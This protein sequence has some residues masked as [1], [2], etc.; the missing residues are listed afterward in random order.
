[1]KNKYKISVIVPVY[2]VER[3][4]DECIK[5]VLN[6]TIDFQKNIQL[7]LV[8]D[9]SPDNSEAICKKYQEKY[10]DNIIYIKQKNAGVSAARNN[11]LKYATGEYINFLDSDDK[12]DKNAFKNGIEIFEKNP[13][14]NLIC[15]RIKNFEGNNDY[16]ILS[17]KFDYNKEIIDIFEDNDCIESHVCNFLIRRSVIGDVLFD[18]NLKYAEDTKFINEILVDNNKIY[19][20]KDSFYFYRKRKEQSSATQKS[21]TDPSYYTSVKYAFIEPFKLFKNKFS[22]IPKYF[23]YSIM[24]QLTYRIKQGIGTS[25]TIKDKEDYINDIKILLNEIDDDVII[26]QRNFNINNKILAL[27]IKYGDS[28]FNKIRFDDKYIYINS[29]IIDEV[30]NLE[31]QLIQF[32]VCNDKLFVFGSVN[33]INDFKLSYKINSKEYSIKKIYKT[34]MNDDFNVKITSINYREYINYKNGDKLEFYIEISGKKYKLKNTF[35]KFSRLNNIINYYYENKCLFE[36]ND[37]LNEIHIENNPSIFKVL[38]LEIRYLMSI[39]LKYKRINVFILRSLYWLTKPFINHNIYLFCDRE[40]MAGDSGEIL[41]KYFNKHNKDKKNKSYFVVDKSSED[42]NKIKEYGNVVSYHTMKY[43]ILFLHSKVI[44]SSHADEYVSNAFGN[45]RKYY[46]DLY[47]F[48]YVYLTHGILL[49]DSSKW[50]NRINK[51]FALNV[52]TSPMEYDSIINGNYYFEK[53]ELIKTGIPRYDNLMNLDVKEENKILF[54]P[55]WRSTLVGNAIPGTQQRPYNPKFKD[56]EYFKFYDKLLNDK[57]LL[58]CLEENNLKIRFC[59]HP[60][61][62]NQKQ[63]FVGNDYVEYITDSNSQYE[64]LSSKM[65]VTDYSSAACDF[66]YLNKP[67]VYANF[68]YD[69]IYDVHY[70]NKGYFDYDEHGFGPNCSNY[71]ETKKEILKLIKNNFKVEKKYSERMKNFFYYRDNKNSE[72]VYN[73]I[74]KLMK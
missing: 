8:D 53:N 63:D 48:K 11:G 35:V 42:Y 51:N 36:L 54:M 62:R 12:W 58:D 41:F 47:K 3:Y 4:L 37:D 30:S 39:L 66:A 6:Q 65:V 34:T 20:V 33:F 19:L 23:Q 57:E 55:S 45:A 44:I 73:E 70:Y 72:R 40:F 59:I 18:T 28:I 67:V 50:L 15:F 25:L 31:N 68:D 64:T 10:S 38:T 49:H 27:Y 26:N 43:R 24:Y 52:V 22:K 13:D 14:I 56:S 5:S 16:H 69:H 32:E 61:F 7:I 9:E 21:I 2:N 74:T 60:S 46:A 71:D 1:M 17:Y 29:T